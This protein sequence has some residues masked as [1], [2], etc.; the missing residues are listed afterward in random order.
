MVDEL[1]GKT[2]IPALQ[3]Q[4]KGNSRADKKNQLA[5]G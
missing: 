1:N 5:T 3:R 4:R 2:I